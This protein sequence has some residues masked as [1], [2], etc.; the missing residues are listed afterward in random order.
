M[1][2]TGLDT[3]SWCFAEFTASFAHRFPRVEP[4]RQATSYLR[5]LLSELER[6]NE[7]TLAEMCGEQ[8]PE[9]LQRLLNLYAWDTDGLRDDVR[10]LVVEALGDPHDGVLLLD[11]TG[12]ASGSRR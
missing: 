12:R 7:W 2:I 6:K 4:R 10:T 11:D 5:G 8:G 3:W 9:R 1:A